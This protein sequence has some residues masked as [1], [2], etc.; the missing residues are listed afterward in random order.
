MTCEKMEIV[1]RLRKGD[2]RAVARLITIIENQSNEA[3]PAIKLLHK[4]TGN[5]Y[6]IGI[7]G[8]PGAGKSTIVN[9]LALN[10]SEKGKKI[11]IIAVD[12]TSPFTGGALLGDRIR[13]QELATNKNVFIRSM[14]TR[15]KSGGLSRATN[16]AIKVLDAYGS[17]IIFV[18]TVG[19]GQSE[20]EIVK[21][22]YT[23]IVIEVPG[24]G[25]DIQAAKAGIMEIGDIFVVNKADRPNAEQ[26][27][28]EL[29]MMLSLNTEEKDWNPVVLKTIAQQNIGILELI[30]TIENH[31]KCLIEN[32][33]INKKRKIMYKNELIEIIKSK[34][35]ESALKGK[36]KD[37]NALTSK[38]ANKEIDPYTAAEEILKR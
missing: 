28:I 33:L 23:T 16:D 36:E 7:T 31:K 30:E 37:L 25:D 14:S 6:V 8:P 4:Y 27:V 15:G 38:I 18:E 26:T 32:N 3:L 11:G 17:D 24:L 29:E 35:L 13:M 20:I 34:I 5:A 9:R 19:A 10:L 21:L 12:P 2:R 1:D 22:A